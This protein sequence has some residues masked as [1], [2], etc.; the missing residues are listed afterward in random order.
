M[1]NSFSI[2]K[3][4]PYKRNSKI[5][6]DKQLRLLA[7]GIAR[8]GWRFPIIVSSKDFTIISGHGRFFAWSKFGEEYGVADPYIVNEESEVLN[9]RPSNKP[10]TEAEEKSFRIFDNKI[11]EAEY[12]LDLQMDDLREIKEIADD[13][14]MDLIVDDDFDLDLDLSLDEEDLSVKKSNL[15]NTNTVFSYNIIFD[16]DTQLQKFIELI[17]TLKIRYSEEETLGAVFESFIDGNLDKFK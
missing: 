1:K 12:D 17:K 6:T 5:H 15:F 2:K 14:L 10:F 8:F 11:A 7:Q 4:K 16:T 3:V 13:E 9:G